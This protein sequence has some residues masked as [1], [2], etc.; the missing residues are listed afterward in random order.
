M[1]FI[2]SFIVVIYSSS[3]LAS[4]IFIYHAP[5]HHWEAKQV[6]GIFQ[7]KYNIPAEIIHIREKAECK[8]QDSRFLELCINRK[9]ELIQLSPSNIEN[10]K[11]SFKTFAR[12]GQ[13]A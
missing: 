13:N 8:Q 1:K 5:K 6:R 7:N 9:G 12:G 2:F 3:A 4:M 10:I 11:K